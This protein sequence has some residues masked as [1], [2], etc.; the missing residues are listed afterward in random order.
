MQVIDWNQFLETGI[1]NVSRKTSM[2]AGVFD[3]VHLGHQA[4]IRLVVS[5]NV[6]FIPA[7]VTFRQNHKKGNRK[8]IQSFQQKMEMLEY[9]GIQITIV[10]DFTA[11]FSR[12]SGI[13][14]LELLLKHGNVGFFTAGSNFRCGHNLDT[15]AEKLKAFFASHSIPTEILQEVME[16]GTPISSSRIRTAIAAGDARLAEK[17]LAHKCL[18]MN[19]IKKEK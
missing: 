3:G 2:T 9:L 6:D 1:K 16:G 7:V 11:E 19:N 14:F 4:L 15:D 17:M 10:I 8:D 5:H 12:M 13:E 18:R